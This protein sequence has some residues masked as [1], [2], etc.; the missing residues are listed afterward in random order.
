MKAMAEK[1]LFIIGMSAFF[2]IIV[3][4]LAAMVLTLKHDAHE[5]KLTH[6]WDV[7]S[8]DAPFGTYWVELDGGGNLIGFSID[9]NLQESYTVKY[10]E[11][12]VLRTQIFASTD[13][14][15][16][17]HLT[18]ND[19]MTMERYQHVWRDY[20]GDESL[21]GPTTYHLYIPDPSIMED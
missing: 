18:D 17:V 8:C 15:F 14:Y 6:Q 13:P 21:R 3:T 5:L 16:I 11:G 7:W 1:I 10:L 9:S 20:L 19:T 4:G 2:A 12:D